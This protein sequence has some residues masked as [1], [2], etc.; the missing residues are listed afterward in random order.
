MGHLGR[1]WHR[2]GCVWGP[3]FTLRG[4][5]QGPQ[6]PSLS[7]VPICG[8]WRTCI[9]PCFQTLKGR[10]QSQAKAKASAQGSHLWQASY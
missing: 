6:Y 1:A 10:Y 3:L 8:S 7:P 5:C 9:F 4:I 2:V